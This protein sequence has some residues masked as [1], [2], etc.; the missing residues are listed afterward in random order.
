MK[1]SICD[2]INVMKINENLLHIINIIIYNGLVMYMRYTCVYTLWAFE[3]GPKG[4]RKCHVQFVWQFWITHIMLLMI[5]LEVFH[6][7]R[8]NQN[9]A[10]LNERCLFVEQVLLY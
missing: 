10:I 1:F 5:F 8:Y 6:E 2:I 7:M 4:L 3:K 9:L